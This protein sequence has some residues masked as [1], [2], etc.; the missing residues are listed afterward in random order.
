MASAH[1]A[2]TAIGRGKVASMHEWE[3]DEAFGR[4]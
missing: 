3:K 1:I 2:E 4:D